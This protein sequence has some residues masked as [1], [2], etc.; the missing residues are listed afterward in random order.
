MTTRAVADSPASRLAGSSDGEGVTRGD[1]ETDADGDALALVVADTD[2][3]GEFE[4]VVEAV[5]LGEGLGDEDG[6]VEGLG[7]GCG[8]PTSK[9]Y[10][11]PNL[12]PGVPVPA[13]KLSLAMRVAVPLESNLRRTAMSLRASPAPCAG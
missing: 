2:G 4:G 8:P 3:V 9:M 1:A 7:V 6:V 11:A 10:T 5:L 13:S 12:C